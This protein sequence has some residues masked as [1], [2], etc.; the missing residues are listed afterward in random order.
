[1]AGKRDYYAVETQAHRDNYNAKD[2]E[3]R[4]LADARGGTEY[5]KEMYQAPEVLET[6]IDTTT[7]LQNWKR[8]ASTS[9]VISTTTASTASTFPAPADED[10]ATTTT[11]PKGDLLRLSND[12]G[13]YLCEFIYYTSLLEYWRR[14]PK[15]LAKGE[16]PVVF[17]HVPGQAEEEDLKRGRIVAIGLIK[18]LVETREGMGK[19]EE[20]KGEGFVVGF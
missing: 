19:V 18:A 7:L 12:A 16:R 20:G 15:G 13:H 5:W 10:D 11:A 3:G 8:N 9:T 2:V 6:G 4:T 14:E 17:L 1:M